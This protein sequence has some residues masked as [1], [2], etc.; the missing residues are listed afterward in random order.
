MNSKTWKEIMMGT[1]S[2]TVVYDDSDK[3]KVLCRMVIWSD[4]YPSGHGADLKDLLKGKVVAGSIGDRTHKTA[5]HTMGCVA[6][7]LITYFKYNAG[8]GGVYLKPI[9][10]NYDYDY[11]YHVYPSKIKVPSE[12]RKGW[13]DKASLIMLDVDKYSGNINDF[14]FENN[15]YFE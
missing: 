5:F 11:V 13:V 15:S 3:T 6:T 9:D 7:A 1:S 8:I 12:R 4:G 10:E 2:C 14:D